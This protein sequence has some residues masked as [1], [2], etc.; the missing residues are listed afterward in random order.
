MQLAIDVSKHFHFDIVGIDLIMDDISQSWLAMGATICE[1][2]AQPQLG[3]SQD[4]ELY[5]MLLKELLVQQGLIPVDLVIKSTA[6]QTDINLHNEVFKDAILTDR[7]GIY[8]QGRLL[9]QSFENDFLAARA[10]LSWRSAKVVVCYLSY[11]ELLK[12]GLPVYHQHIRHIYYSNEFT[13]MSELTR[14]S[15][16]SPNQFKSL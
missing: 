15:H 4:P 8:H 5:P 10:G 1:I 3:A 16:L 9:S 6:N 2:N 7:S 12:Q 14:L 11:E 13:Q